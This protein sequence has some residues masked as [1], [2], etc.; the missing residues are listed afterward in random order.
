MNDTH[1]ERGRILGNDAGQLIQHQ[2]ARMFVVTGA[3][4]HT[5]KVVAET[6]LAQGKPVRVVVRDAAKG[7]PSRARGA[8]VAV[9]A[10][11]DAAALGK[12]LA[13][14]EGV[15]LLVPPNFTS[16]SVIADQQRLVDSLVAAVR[17]ARPRHVVLLSSVGAQLASGTGPI[18]SLHYAEEKLAEVAPLTALRAAYFMENWASV[19][20]VARAQGILPSMLRPGTRVPMV[21]TADIGRAAAQALVEGPAGRR[22]IELFGPAEYSP[23]DV[24]QS[25][26]AILGKPVQKIDVPD[27]G[28]EPALKQAGLTDDMARLYREMLDGFN[29]GR[30]TT[31]QAPARGRVKVDDVLRELLAG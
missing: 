21:A 16:Q 3:T 9:A 31:T 22:V 23:E 24:V 25:V 20:P 2:E 8:E 11:G 26:A 27:E 28:I 13:G 12:A 17:Q 10:L 4:G 14:A 18:Q 30:I 6:L 5:G 7:A 1:G 15:Y 29:A 19:L